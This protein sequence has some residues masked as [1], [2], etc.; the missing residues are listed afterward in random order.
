M[1][2]RAQSASRPRRAGGRRWMPAERRC[3]WTRGLSRGPRRL[4]RRRSGPGTEPPRKPVSAAARHRGG[5]TRRGSL[6]RLLAR[7]G[8]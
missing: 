7:R 3:A 1:A 5:R 6:P 4:A 8:G 2:H